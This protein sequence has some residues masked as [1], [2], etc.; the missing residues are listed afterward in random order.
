MVPRGHRLLRFNGDEDKPPTNG[1]INVVCCRSDV[2]VASTC[3]AKWAA[4][5]KTCREMVE[6]RQLA[7]DLGHPQP[8]T[9]VTTD[10]LCVSNNTLKPNRSKAMDM[11]FYWVKDQFII[12]WAPGLDNF[13]D[14]FTK[15]HPDKHHQLMR[16]Y[17]VK[18]L[19]MTDRT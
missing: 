4:I 5:F 12:R 6:T 17:F 14:F 15:L 18:D 16:Q 19:I 8:P 2:V 1:C 7:E 3:E 9:I 11:R 13:A 10:N